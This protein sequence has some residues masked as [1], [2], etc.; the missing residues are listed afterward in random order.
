M[1]R[2]QNPFLFSSQIFSFF[3]FHHYFKKTSIWKHFSR[4]RIISPVACPGLPRSWGHAPQGHGR[5]KHTKPCGD[6]AF[7]TK[8]GTKRSQTQRPR[9]CF[10]TPGGGRPDPESEVTRLPGFQ[11]R[12]CRP[13]EDGVV[14]GV[15][16]KTSETRGPHLLP[17][18]PDGISGKGARKPDGARR[19]WP[20]TEMNGHLC[21]V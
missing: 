9:R 21:D 18:L 19:T 5:T 15:S 17:T 16:L 6:P 10:S 1:T 3:H 13:T 8:A 4:S 2:V 7:G 20:S 12:K 11:A 14:L